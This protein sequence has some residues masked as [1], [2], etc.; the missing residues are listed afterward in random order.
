M[1]RTRNQSTT[2][3]RRPPDSQCQELSPLNPNQ[4]VASSSS[5]PVRTKW[6]SDCLGSLVRPRLAEVI[7]DLHSQQSTWITGQN[8]DGF[9]VLQCRIQGRPEFGLY[10]PVIKYRDP[11]TTKDHTDIGHMCTWWSLVLLLASIIEEVK[12]SNTCTRISRVLGAGNL[13]PRIT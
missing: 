4:L 9:A 8:P 6:K 13:S 10:N 1:T 7:L 11:S 2:S 12:L 3:V 5:Q